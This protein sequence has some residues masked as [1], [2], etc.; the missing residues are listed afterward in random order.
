MHALARDMARQLGCSRGEARA[1]VLQ[2]EQAGLLAVRN[3]KV[4]LPLAPCGAR[5]EVPGNG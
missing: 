3:G 2:L 5:G 1:A 4:C